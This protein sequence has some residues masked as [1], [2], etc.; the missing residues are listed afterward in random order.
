MKTPDLKQSKYFMDD[1]REASRLDAKVNADEFIEDFLLK[2]LTINTG[3]TIVDIGCG[4]GA[5]SSAIAK[6][7]R[8][9]QIKGVDL[10]TQRLEAAR[11]KSKHLSNTEFI[12]GSIYELP[13]EDNSADIL[14]TRFL[15]EY[16]QEPVNGI[17]EMFRVCKKGGTVMLQDLDGQL[18]FHYPET[19]ENMDKVLDGLA[20]TG[21]DPLI[22][23]KLLHYGLEA[24][25]KL[26]HMDIRP[27]HFFAGQ[28]D[29][30]ND[31][32]WDLKLEIALPK[33][34][35]IL[36]SSELAQ[37]F[38]QDFMSYL[39]DEKTFMYSNLFTVYLKKV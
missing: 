13:L 18:L 14:Y 6:K 2:Y 15:L 19:I 16:L 36:G 11:N 37:K 8:S 5:I 20:K 23:R 4:A 22:G 30:H 24:G 3:A 26:E 10:S 31:Y 28:I 29:A 21:F 32:L 39:R 7:F 27:Y 33:F 1:P 25:F 34:A 38:K 12:E 35:D 17:K 9:S